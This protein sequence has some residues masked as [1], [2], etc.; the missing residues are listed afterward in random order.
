MAVAMLLTFQIIFLIN[1]AV[2]S[3]PVKGMPNLDDTTTV[4]GGSPDD[5]IK[6]GGCPCNNPCDFTSPPPPPPP[7]L[8]PPPPPP[9]MAS[10]TPGV[11]NC[12]PPPTGGGYAL[13]PPSYIYITGPPE[14]LYPVNP[15]FSA[16]RRNF[17]VAPSLL[18]MLGL[19][20]VLIVC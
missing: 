13:G 9:K 2:A 15:Y 10:P 4:S 3:S 18:V 17:W 11:N 6:C 1:H 5:L 8:P 19:L 16:A 7:Q 20:G 12:P 14:N